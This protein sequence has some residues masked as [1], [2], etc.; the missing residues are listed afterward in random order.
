MFQIKKR[1]SK[2][3]RVALLCHNTMV[4][5]FADS[6]RDNGQNMTTHLAISLD[7]GNWALLKERC[8]EIVSIAEKDLG[9]TRPCPHTLRSAVSWPYQYPPTQWHPPTATH[10]SLGESKICCAADNCH[11]CSDTILPSL[12]I[13]NFR[14]IYFLNELKH[15]QFLIWCSV[16]D[17]R[18][19]ESMIYAF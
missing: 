1:I 13:Q 8:K 10:P 7:F 11:P 14:N 19:T 6:R 17:I 2:E 18:G 9:K 5:C 4:F 3:G 12:S 16:P 15:N